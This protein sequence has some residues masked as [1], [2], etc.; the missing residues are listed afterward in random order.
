[1]QPS[2]AEH[3]RRNNQR[4]ATFLEITRHLTSTTCTSGRATPLLS[5]SMR[6]H[7]PKKRP[8]FP[9]VFSISREKAENG[10]GSLW[11][12]VPDARLSL[13]I[14]HSR[15][16]PTCTNI[17]SEPTFHADR[18]VKRGADLHTATRWQC[19]PVQRLITSNAWVSE[20]FETRIRPPN[21]SCSSVI[22][23]IALPTPT[24]QRN[25]ATIDVALNGANKP[26]LAKMITNQNST[27]SKRGL[28]V[29][30]TPCASC[31]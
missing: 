20:A 13:Q 2:Q 7:P 22:I 19:A 17:E 12:V 10:S 16:P 31:Q 26:K 27:S 21:G 24:E 5:P 25:I 11:M 30:S 1:M 8:A 3:S 15:M 29:L 9:R 28:G 23:R 4:F 18:G 6:V 14:R